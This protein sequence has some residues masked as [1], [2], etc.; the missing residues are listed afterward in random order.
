MSCCR[1]FPA[2]ELSAVLEAVWASAVISS[3]RSSSKHLG[4]TGE[5]NMPHATFGAWVIGEFSRPI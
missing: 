1:R 2:G 5:V 3:A 4:I